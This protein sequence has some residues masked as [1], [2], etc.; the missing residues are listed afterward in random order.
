MVKCVGCKDA[1]VM[2]S[3]VVL[4]GAYSSMHSGDICVM[5]TCCS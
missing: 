3:I 1:C 5:W 2:L 4:W